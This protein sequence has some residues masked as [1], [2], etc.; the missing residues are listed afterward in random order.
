MEILESKESEAFVTK[1]LSR[2]IERIIIRL[3]HEARHND[4]ASCPQAGG[5]IF[6]YL[7]QS[8]VVASGDV[9]GYGESFC[10]GNSGGETR[11]NPL[12]SLAGDFNDSLDSQDE[13]G[14]IIGGAPQE[15]PRN[16]EAPEQ[17]EEQ[18]WWNGFLGWFEE[19]VEELIAS[20]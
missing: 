5:A 2:T 12:V 3:N 17:N 19:K 11:I 8:N 10:S 1:E 20:H 6:G 13:S 15:F 7:P 4:R 16:E 18:F 9:N 14:V